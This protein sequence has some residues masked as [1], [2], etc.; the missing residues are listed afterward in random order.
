M[1]VDGTHEIQIETPM[2]ARPAT[3]TLVSDGAALSGKF[4]S[5]QGEQAWDGGSVDGN[6]VAWSNNFSGAMGP[7]Q[8][9][10]KGTVDGDTLSGTV[11][12]GAFGAGTFSGQRV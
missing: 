4:G 9:D 2:G 12:F 6:D 11:Q 3:L 7:M 8:L 10:F 1:A 5:Q